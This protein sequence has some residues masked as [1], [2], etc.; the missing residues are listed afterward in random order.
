MK[1]VVVDSDTIWVPDTQVL[2]DKIVSSTVVENAKVT[3]RTLQ[4]RGLNE[5]VARCCEFMLSRVHVDGMT[6]A[7]CMWVAAAND[8]NKVGSDGRVTYELKA[9]GE[10]RQFKPA[11]Q[12]DAYRSDGRVDPRL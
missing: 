10:K 6:T 12:R 9:G 2:R 7:R 1:I 3:H 11:V 5:E 4:L 8:K